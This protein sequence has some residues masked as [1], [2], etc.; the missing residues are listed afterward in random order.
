LKR[1]LAVRGGVRLSKLCNATLEEAEKKVRVL[2]KNEAGELEEGPFEAEADEEEDAGETMTR[3]TR[4]MTTRAASLKAPVL[5]VKPEELKR[6]LTAGDSAWT[7]L[8]HG[9]FPGGRT[10]L[11]NWAGHGV[12][13]HGGGET[14]APH[15]GPG[16]GRGLRRRRPP[17]HD[18][19]LRPRIHPYLLPHPRHCR[20][21]TTTT[22][23]GAANQHKV[24]G[25]ALAI[26]A[27]THSSP[28]LRDPG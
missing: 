6:Y 22:S 15:P 25:D 24:F 14:P 13:P 21:W 27:G 18:G 7:G 2:L 3:T 12:Q 1:P 20:P 23:G 28:G 11:P 16:R 26:L 5:T 8:W 9:F 17:G 10:G 19:R 4:K